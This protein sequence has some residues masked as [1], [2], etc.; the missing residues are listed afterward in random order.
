MASLPLPTTLS[1]PEAL[2][3]AIRETGESEQAV[4]DALARAFGDYNIP[5]SAEPEGDI[6]WD[7]AI[8]DWEANQVSVPYR[9]PLMGAARTYTEIK[10][11]RDLLEQWLLMGTEPELNSAP[12][13]QAISGPPSKT[14]TRKLSDAPNRRGRKPGSGEL[15]DSKSLEMMGTL[16][17]DGECT[18]PWAAAGDDCVQNLAKGISFD[19]IQ[20]RLHRK[21]QKFTHTK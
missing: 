19:A 1:L 8:I 4:K 5:V 17:A 11:L 7:H 3:Y 13:E 2:D 18:N 21:Y 10:M 14:D 15:D 6:D 20:K 9:D 16:I 12:D